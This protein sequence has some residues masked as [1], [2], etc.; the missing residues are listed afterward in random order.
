MVPGTIQIVGVIKGNGTE[1]LLDVTYL[2]ILGGI[3]LKMVS[4]L[5]RIIAFL[6]LILGVILFFT[7]H[8]FLGIVLAIIAFIIF[9]SRRNAAL[10][11]SAVSDGY[12]R[13]YH[14]TNKSYNN[15]TDNNSTLDAGDSNEND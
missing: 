1:Y 2:S 5:F 4:V 12:N 9:P 7:E 15:E 3:N 10:Q 8:E 11:S 13:E 6:A 14:S